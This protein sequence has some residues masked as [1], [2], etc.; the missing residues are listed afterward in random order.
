MVAKMDF[1]IGAEENDFL[2]QYEHIA[3]AV[4]G[5][6]IELRL[7]F[8]YCI[9]RSVKGFFLAAFNVG[10]E[11]GY[12]FAAENVIDAVGR[13]FNFSALRKL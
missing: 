12:L 8:S 11:K 13:N 4:V 1:V 10:L 2:R 6:Y 9:F 7:V 5:A 3:V